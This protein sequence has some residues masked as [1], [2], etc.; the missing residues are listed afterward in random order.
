MDVARALGLDSEI[1]L[2]AYAKELLAQ[3]KAS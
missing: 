1:E 3:E 2:R